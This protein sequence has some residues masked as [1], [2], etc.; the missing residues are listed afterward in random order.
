M[1]SGASCL[2]LHFY[3]RNY[4]HSK[5]L[6]TDTLD[7]YCLILIFDLLQRVHGYYEDKNYI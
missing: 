1:I 4:I 6:G 2:G 5:A 7:G 3:K